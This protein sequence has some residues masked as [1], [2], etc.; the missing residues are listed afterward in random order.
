[1]APR[2]YIKKYLKEMRNEIV[3]SIQ[4]SQESD[5]WWGLVN[6]DSMKGEEFINQLREYQL[7][8]M[9]YAP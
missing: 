7:L 8:K 5:K 4:L 2:D 3:N 1:M 9:D 6:T